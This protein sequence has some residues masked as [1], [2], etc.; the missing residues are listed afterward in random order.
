M[1]V[2][3]LYGQKP[4]TLDFSTTKVLVK[5]TS[6]SPIGWGTTYKCQLIKLQQGSLPA[7]DSSFTISVSVD[8]TDLTEMQKDNF[9]E[10]VLENTKSKSAKP[11]LQSGTSGLMDKTGI[12]WK[13]KTIQ[14]N[15]PSRD[16]WD[17]CDVYYNDSL[18]AQFNDVSENLTV[19]LSKGNISPTDSIT[20]KHGDDT[21][22]IDCTFSL[23]VFD[24]QKTKLA[25][26]KTTLFFGKLILPLS[27]LVDIVNNTGSYRL[28][29]Y[30]TETNEAGNDGPTKLVLQLTLK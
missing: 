4:T 6:I 27:M 21:P 22:C 13:L 18:I 16:F 5:I 10:V 11:Y 12:I 28:D 25:E 7:V 1:T 3:V 23:Y 2:S 24:E 20:I 29:F 19:Q 26:T 14:P 9:Y 30:F 15:A 8:R 17:Y